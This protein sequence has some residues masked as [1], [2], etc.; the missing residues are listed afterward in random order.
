M[1]VFGIISLVIASILCAMVLINGVTSWFKR[2]NKGFIE[3]LFDIIIY[4]IWITTAVFLIK[5]V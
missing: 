3:S 4:A 1:K 2:N 5:G